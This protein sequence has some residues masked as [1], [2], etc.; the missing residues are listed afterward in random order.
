MSICA[1]FTQIKLEFTAEITLPYFDRNKYTIL[2]T[3]ALEKRLW[4]HNTTGQQAYLLHFQ[5]PYMGREKLPKPG[6]GVYGC[7]MGHGKVLLL[8]L[9]QRV[10]APDGPKT[11][12]IYIQEAYG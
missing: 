9:W 8:P 12:D 1:A 5:K 7:D 10:L 6:A 11:S 4:C 3:D 2:Q